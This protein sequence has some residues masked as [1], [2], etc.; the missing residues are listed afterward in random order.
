MKPFVR[1]SHTAER[2]PV[3]P[4]DKKLLHHTETFCCFQRENLPRDIW[5]TSDTGRELCLTSGLFGDLEFR[6]NE[7]QVELENKKKTEDFSENRQ[8]K[9]RRMEG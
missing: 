1:S 2:L 5:R 4:P 8:M 3:Q 9:D 6:A 7:K